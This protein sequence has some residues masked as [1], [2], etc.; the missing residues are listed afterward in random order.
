MSRD[1]SGGIATGYGLDGRGSVPGRGKICFSIPKHSDRLWG[2]PSVLFNGYRGLFPGVKRLG[3]NA[4]P[5]SS[6]E[7]KKGGAIPL[8]PH[9]SPWRGVY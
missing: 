7:I 2:P 5:L 1:N 4:A 6:A 3:R 8:L 9:I